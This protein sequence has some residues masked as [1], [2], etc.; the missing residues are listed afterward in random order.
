M[1]KVLLCI[2]NTLNL[3][4]HTGLHRLVPR[5]GDSVNR[6]VE[7]TMV[8]SAC[9]MLH[10]VGRAQ[11]KPAISYP[12]AMLTVGLAAWVC[13]CSHLASTDQHGYGG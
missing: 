10:R 3:C 1:D 11:G 7:G 8:S 5:G 2:T 6:L 9:H 4:L 12:M 13:V